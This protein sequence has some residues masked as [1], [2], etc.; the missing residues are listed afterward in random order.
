[1]REAKLPRRQCFTQHAVK[2]RVT[3][4]WAKLLGEFTA[5]QLNS[6]LKAIRI[7]AVR[8]AAQPDKA[9]VIHIHQTRAL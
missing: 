5:A 1:M 2:F 4:Q 7:V 6:G 9:D 3:P 8:A